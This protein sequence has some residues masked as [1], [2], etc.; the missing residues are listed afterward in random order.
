MRVSLV[1][2]PSAALIYRHHSVFEFSNYDLAVL[3]VTI[4]VSQIITDS[5]VVMSLYSHRDSFLAEH[6]FNFAQMNPVI[7]GPRTFRQEQT[8]YFLSQTRRAEMVVCLTSCKSGIRPITRASSL[9]RHHQPRLLPHS[10]RQAKVP[11][12]VIPLMPVSSLARRSAVWYSLLYWLSSA[13]VVD[14]SFVLRTL[15][16]L[17]KNYNI[18]WMATGFNRIRSNKTSH[19]NTR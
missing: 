4:T 16:L 18:R 10:L 1:G 15:L 9:T 11:Q 8:S 12:A 13:Y 5:I 3:P 6:L 19:P 7:T 2:L 17:R 14:E